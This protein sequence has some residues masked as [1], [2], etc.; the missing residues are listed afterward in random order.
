MDVYRSRKYVHIKSNLVKKA[1]D[2]DRLSFKDTSSQTGK[3][4]VVESLSLSLCKKTAH[5]LI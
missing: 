5:Y 2:N 1:W 4:G 3:E